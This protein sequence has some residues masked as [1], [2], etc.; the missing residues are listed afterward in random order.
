MILFKSLLMMVTIVLGLGSFKSQ[1][2]TCFIRQELTSRATGI[3]TAINIAE[4]TQVSVGDT[5]ISLDDRLLVVGLKEAEAALMMTRSQE[6]LAKDAFDR[7]ASLK[8]GDSVS[9]QQIVESQLKLSQARAGVAQA[10]AVVE[11]LK[12]QISD[13]KIRAEIAG[14]VRGL[15]LVKGLFVQFG[16]SLGYIEASAPEAGAQSG[17]C[18]DGEKVR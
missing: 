17:T 5:I 13:T 4:N 14:I 8:G 3:L 12:I 11:R 2:A 16:Q 18:L 6:K 1:A 7:V 9:K 10:E 15:P